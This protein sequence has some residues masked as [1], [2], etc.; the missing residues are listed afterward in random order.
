MF[1]IHTLTNDMFA[2]REIDAVVHLPV[3][4]A[5][6]LDTGDVRAFT[7]TLARCDPSMRNFF[8]TNGALV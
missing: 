8:V 7:G 5:D 2:G 3:A 1:T 4:T 6:L